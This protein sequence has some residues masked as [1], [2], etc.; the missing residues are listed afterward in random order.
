VPAAHF[1]FLAPCSEQLSAAVPRICADTP[2]DFDRAAF[3]RTFDAEI[4]RFLS[5]H[6]ISGPDRL[7]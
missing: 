2:P 6:L 4:V 5:E 7:H 3:H 1:A